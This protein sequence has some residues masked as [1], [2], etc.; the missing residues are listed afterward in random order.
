[1]GYKIAIVGD[2][3]DEVDSQWKRPFSG[4]AG[5]ELNRMLLD[6]GISREEC[7]V[8]NVFNL[9]PGASDIAP[10]CSTKAAGGHIP[11]WP[12]VGTSKYV[13]AKY[14][15][16]LDRLFRELTEVRPNVVLA[17]GAVASWALLKLTSIGKIRG[18]ATVSP[19]VEG[20][21]V[22]PCH[23]P[24]TIRKQY[25][26]RHVT[27]LDMVKA[28][29][30]AE[31]PEIRKI[32]REFWLDPGLEDIERFYNQHWLATARGSFDIETAAG[33][34][35]CIGFAPTIDRC[36]V[37]PFFDY[38]QSSGSYWPT[39]QEEILAWRWVE[40]FLATSCEKVGQNG[41]YDMQYLWMVYGIPTGNYAHDTMLLHHALQPESP[42]GLD[43]LGSVYTN[44][45]AWK[46]QRPRGQHTI[47]REE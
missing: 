21:K 18:A 44:E 41:L 14:Q 35:T 12:A 13:M 46:T 31:F 5:D 39:A 29:K 8:T 33:Q 23:H 4:P 7:F 36:L 34:I 22:I 17:M 38:R 6:A 10:L 43:F 47:K 37:I 25:D 26:L 28:K 30:E 1:M 32:T 15:G 11:G 27:V 40:K 19:V 3:Y 2:F 42:K 45:P 16:E 20:L 9:Y 24:G